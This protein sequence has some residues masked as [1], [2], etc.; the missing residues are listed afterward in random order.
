M[1]KRDEKMKKEGRN[2]VLR[3]ISVASGAGVTLLTCLAIGL[4]LGDKIDCFIGW[5][6]PGGI[7]FGGLLGAVVALFSIYKQLQ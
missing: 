3:A 4:Y 7:L 6:F 5:N 2:E 1:S